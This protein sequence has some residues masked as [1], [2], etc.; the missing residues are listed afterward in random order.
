M[1]QI[2]DTIVSNDVI[3]KEFVCNLSKCRGIC[4]VEGDA[5]A[6]LDEDELPIL[7]A[8]YPKVKPFLRKEG[9]DAIEKQGKY[10]KDLDGDWVTPLVDKKECAYVVFDENGTTICGIEKAYE[11]GVIEYKKPISCH[12]Y[13]IRLS[14][15]NAFTAVNY[16][17]WPICSDACELGKS[18]NITVAE[19]TKD[20]LIRKFGED[21]Y[22]E[23]MIAKKELENY[24]LF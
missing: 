4:C 7:D 22:Q 10:E 6:P 20:A 13:P 9:I 21:W 15:F 3:K 14:K 17:K 8:I 18:L 11:E 16:H 19:F 2:K 12:L 1:I 24:K 23:L 5:G